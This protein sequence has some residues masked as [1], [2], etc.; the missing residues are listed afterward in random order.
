M[1]AR[2]WTWRGRRG[3]RGG[4]ICVNEDEDVDVDVDV[5]RQGAAA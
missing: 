5:E 1:Q 2:K 4:E 3:K